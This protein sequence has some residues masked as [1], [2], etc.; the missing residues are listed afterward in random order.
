MYIKN[1]YKKLQIIY[2]SLKEKSLSL[3]ESYK[4]LIKN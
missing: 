3:N 2:N 1:K 4:N